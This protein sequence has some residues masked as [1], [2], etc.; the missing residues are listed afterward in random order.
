[1]STHSVSAPA[2]INLFLAVTGRRPDGFHDLLSVAVP[3]LW[4]DTVEAA[5][6]GA[7]LTVSCD[8]PSV[9]TDASNLV[10]KAAAAFSGAT[11]WPGGAHFK[12]TKRIPSAAG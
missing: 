4:G 8:D 10:I 7:S 2:K 11:G 6:G 5:A 12:I 1:M 3:L 9:P